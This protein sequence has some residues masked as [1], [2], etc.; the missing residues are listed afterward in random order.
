MNA[1]T[2]VDKKPETD[3]A[4]RPCCE[5]RLAACGNKRQESKGNAEVIGPALPITQ[6]AW[7]IPAQVL[8]CQRS[9]QSRRSQENHP[10]G[11]LPH[12]NSC[13]QTAQHRFFPDLRPQKYRNAAN[14]PNSITKNAS[15]TMPSRRSMKSRMGGPNQYSSALTR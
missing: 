11:C 1:Q 8:E 4:E 15:V 10:K 3:R 7:L 14:P 13:D 6:R 9:K 2:R 5:A 12:P